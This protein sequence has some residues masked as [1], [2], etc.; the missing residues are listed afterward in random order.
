MV[1]NALTTDEVQNAVGG[2]VAC[3]KPLESSLDETQRGQLRWA[4][5]LERYLRVERELH[6][7][8]VVAVRDQLI[9]ILDGV[10]VSDV[11]GWAQR[12]ADVSDGAQLGEVIAE[13]LGELRMRGTEGALIDRIHEV[14]RDAVDRENEAMAVAPR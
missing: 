5:S 11:R 2:V 12:V 3:L 7:R 4:T 9:D 13:L 6:H 1:F 10:R 14:L 8:L